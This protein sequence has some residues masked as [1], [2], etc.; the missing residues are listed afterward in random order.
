[1]AKKILLD[2]RKS[3]FMEEKSTFMKRFTQQLDASTPKNI[4]SRNLSEIFEGEGSE[5]YDSDNAS[6]ISNKNNLISEDHVRTYVRK[7]TK[8]VSIANVAQGGESSHSIK[9]HH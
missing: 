7:Q 3:S 6:M 9:S 5:M 8:K 1:M 2:K 4:L